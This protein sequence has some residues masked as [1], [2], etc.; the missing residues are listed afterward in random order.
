MTEEYRALC[1]EIEADIVSILQ[2][3]KPTDVTQPQIGRSRMKKFVYC[4]DNLLPHENTKVGAVVL[5]SSYATGK[6]EACS[7]L[8]GGG[9]EMIVGDPIQLRE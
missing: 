1:V 3:A 5:I 6:T 2:A 7:V 8:L 4:P 9:V